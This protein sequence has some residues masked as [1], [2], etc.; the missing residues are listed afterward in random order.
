MPKPAVRH[1]P[2]RSCRTIKP[3]NLQLRH[4]TAADASAISALVSASF[5]QH[6]AQ[7]WEPQAQRHFFDENEPDKLRSKIADAS[8]CLVC[9]HGAELLGVIFLPRPTLVQLFFVAPGHLRRGIGRKLWSAARAELVQS[10]PD[11]R[12]VE[13]NSSPYALAVYEALGFFPISKP[14]RRKGAVATRMACWL[15]GESLESEQHVT[16]REARS[17]EAAVLCEAERAVVLQFDGL[18]VSE[19]AELSQVAFEERIAAQTLGQTK[20]LVAE[21]HGELVG[22][23]S[24][25]PMGLQKVAHVLRLDMCVHL[26]QWNRGHGTRLL[27]ELLAW[28]GENRNAHKVE[29]LVRSTNTTAVR[30]YE[31]AGF[32]HEGRFIDRVRL[33]DGR[34]VDDLGMG[35]VLRDCFASRGSTASDELSSPAAA[36]D[37]VKRQAIHSPQSSQCELGTKS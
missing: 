4:A 15:P 6:I 29:L 14:Y 22:H 10:H 3:V 12:T 1:L 21:Q 26:G 11:V 27:A 7:D 9:E 18:L 20:V 16:V 23:A 32:A 36:A 8:L 2:H 28:A 33:R 13:L 25:Y 17:D 35:L 19:P 31:R 37:H 30:L 24:L 34:F 5:D